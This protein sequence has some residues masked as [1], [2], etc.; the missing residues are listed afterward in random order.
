VIN[1]PTWEA[2][3]TLFPLLQVQ[4]LAAAAAALLADPRPSHADGG[5]RALAVLLQKYALGLGWK[6][7]LAAARDPQPAAP[8]QPPTAMQNGG[9]HAPSAAAADADEAPKHASAVAFLQQLRATLQ[10]LRC[11]LPG[12]APLSLPA[13]SLPPCWL[14]RC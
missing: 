5:A 8:P 13:P 12:F 10:V 4:R 14:L 3:D 7:Q 6:L 1:G 11:M 2:N 9:A